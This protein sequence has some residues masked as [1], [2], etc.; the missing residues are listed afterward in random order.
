LSK[1]GKEANMGNDTA[2]SKFISLILRHK[3]ETIGISLNE[4][5]WADVN[6]LI[7][8]IRT[9]GRSIDMETLERIVAEN[10]KQRFNFNADRTKIRANQGHSIP[11]GIELP[12]SN[13][14][15][16]LYHGTASGFLDSIRE[17]GILKQNRQY[18]HLSS[19]IQTALA[20]GKRHGKP[21]VLTIDA[22]KMKED[23]YIFYFSVNKVWLCGDIP[24]KYIKEHDITKS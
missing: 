21:I 16:V 10:N 19:D 4:H 23:G 6:E 15:D 9:S 5:G 8:G 1:K 17:K 24:W 7:S 2:M 13:P 20:V 3:P 22:K 18:V 12:E 11:V 14:P